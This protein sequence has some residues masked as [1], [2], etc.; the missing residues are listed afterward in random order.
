MLT[1]PAELYTAVGR[2][3][4]RDPT[5]FSHLYLPPAR[6]TFLTDNRQ[7]FIKWVVD[8]T[9]RE[10][11]GLLYAQESGIPTTELLTHGSHLGRD[12][13]VFRR[14]RDDFSHL[15]NPL[16]LLQSIWN[17]PGPATAE[18]MDL[19]SK[20]ERMLANLDQCE[21]HKLTDEI[22]SLMG[23]CQEEAGE[24]EKS[25]LL[26][27]CWVHGDCHERNLFLYGGESLVLDWE[28]HGLGYRE[29]DAG[30]WL[31]V[32]MT[33]TLEPNPFPFWEGLQATDLNLNLVLLDSRMS[34]LRALSYQLRWETMPEYVPALLELARGA[35]PI[36]RELSGR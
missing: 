26:R 5:D 16:E 21:R 33:E 10:R 24:L 12:I 34:A 19:S 17:L 15:E 28:W 35:H 31:Q 9:H 22:Y 7:V 29:M 1:P 23:S 2:L 11:D 32:N 13:L 36:Y 6:T 18:P 8:Q 25:G 27:R 20:Y 14:L 30:K 4:K 3:L